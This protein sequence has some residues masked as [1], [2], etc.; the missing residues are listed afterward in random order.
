MEQKE[1]KKQRNISSVVYC[2][3]GCLVMQ[4]CIDFVMINNTGGADEKGRN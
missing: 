4:K 1:K 2:P 3:A